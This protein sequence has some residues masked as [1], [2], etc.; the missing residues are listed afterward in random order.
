MLGFPIPGPMSCTLAGIVLI[1]GLIVLAYI[2]CKRK[3][4]ENKR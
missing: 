3:D 1:G 2:V 4:E